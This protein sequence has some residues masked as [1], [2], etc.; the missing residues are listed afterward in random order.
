ML[1]TKAYYL[2]KR[3][4]LYSTAL[5]IIQNFLPPSSNDLCLSLVILNGAAEPARND[6][7]ELVISKRAIFW[8]CHH[9]TTLAHGLVFHMKQSI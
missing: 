3:Y 8:H 4:T 2:K 9:K 6:K 7:A 1:G 5:S